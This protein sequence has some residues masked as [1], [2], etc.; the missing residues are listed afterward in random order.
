MRNTNESRSNLLPHYRRSDAAQDGAELQHTP[1]RELPS[2]LRVV[3]V[4]APELRADPANDGTFVLAVHSTS[5]APSAVA[6]ELP[7]AI[8]IGCTP[9]DDRG[10]ALC[11]E[12]RQAG[13]ALPILLLGA[14]D[15]VRERVAAFEAGADDFIGGDEAIWSRVEVAVL[16]A[17][18]PRPV[19]PA[20]LDKPGATAQAGGLVVHL[21]SE[22]VLL[23]RRV[24]QLSRHQ[25]AILIRLARTPGVVVSREELCAVVKM[26][27]GVAFKNLHNEV[28]RLRSQL[29]NE[30]GMRIR[31]VRAMGYLLDHTS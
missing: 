30:A 31:S 5:S 15:S 22:A 16:R 18:K 24:L 21:E 12:L 4:D 1:P 14:T 25:R 28:F 2:P 8:L 3:V 26:V 29:G 11:R 10:F 19:A 9:N 7:D 6:E 17:R 27:P 20:D 13:A 23:G